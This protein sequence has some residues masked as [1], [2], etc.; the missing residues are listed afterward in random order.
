L[1]KSKKTLHFLKDYEVILYGYYVTGEF[2]QG[3]DVDFA[4]ITR[5]KDND[6]NLELL[7]SFIGKARSIYNI[8]IFELLPLKIKATAMSDY[9][10]IFG[11]ELEIS[12]YLYGYRKLWDDQK[13]RI[14]GGYFESYK[15]KIAAMKGGKGDM[16][17]G[18]RKK[19]EIEGIGKC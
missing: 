15:E 9:T 10:T 6:K 3:S 11:D 18:I 1:K 5:S 4:V 12:E 17:V 7:K 16:V 8:R 14:M 19:R 13:Q 2:R